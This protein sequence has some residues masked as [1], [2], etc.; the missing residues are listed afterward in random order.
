MLVFFFL[1]CSVISACSRKEQTENMQE[2]VLLTIGDSTLTLRDVLIRIPGGLAPEDSAAMFATIVDSWVEQLLISDFAVENINDIER[3]D[4]LTNQ[5]RNR[6][7]AQQYRRQLHENG[8]V[9]VSDDDL[10]KYYEKHKDS[11]LLER[12]VVKGILIKLPTDAKRLKEVRK[13]VF[14]G[15]PDDLDKLEKYGLRETLQYSIF[16][17]RWVDWN[18][19]AEQIPYRFYD[20]DAFLELEQNFETS[21]NGVTYLLH[22]SGYVK[23]GD[24][25]PQEYAKLAITELLEK[26][27]LASYERKLLD[28]LRNKAFKDGKLKGVNYDLFNHKYMVKETEKAEKNTK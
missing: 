24:Q 11:L 25:M 10:K 3:I 4:R 5:Y 1:A 13:W 20:A 21:Y 8:K 28:A 22:I 15:K 2:E 19:V 7:I 23:T 9:S 6:L 12:P 18:N 26:E 27:S 17:D 14:S 16:E